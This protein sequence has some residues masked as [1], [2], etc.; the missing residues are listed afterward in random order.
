MFSKDVDIESV[1]FRINSGVYRFSSLSEYTGEEKAKPAA[2]PI[3][4]AKNVQLINHTFFEVLEEYRNK[5]N[6][7][8]IDEADVVKHVDKNAE[9]GVFHLYENVL[10]SLMDAYDKFEVSDPATAEKLADIIDNFIIT[11]DK[12]ESIDVGDYYKRAVKDLRMFGI[13]LTEAQINQGVANDSQRDD[14]AV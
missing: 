9:K 10:N 2:N 11:N 12:G 3:D 5:N 6:L 7:G 8:D 13:K 1:F 4:V 14:K